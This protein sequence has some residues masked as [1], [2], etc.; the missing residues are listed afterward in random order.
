MAT[1]KWTI[2][3]EDGVHTVELKHGTI[4]G[5][6]S[7]F[8]DGKPLKLLPGEEK[9]VYDTGST[10]PFNISDHDCVVIIRSS[11]F[12]FEYE[13]TVDG[14]SVDSGLRVDK[15]EAS[16]VTPGAVKTRRVVV[17]VIFSI[18]GIICLGFNWW[19]VN[20][21]GFYSPELAMLGPA[22]LVAAAYYAIFPDDPWVLPKPFPIRLIIMLVLAI[23]LG[24]AN[25]YAIENGIY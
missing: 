20:T 23:G 3:L 4:S 17:V 16:R 15:E 21:Q 18:A 2:N 12:S 25:W 22:V 1:R 10:H 13:L 14:I 5:K 19:S 7:I 6:R 9:K 24:L 8:V 11:G